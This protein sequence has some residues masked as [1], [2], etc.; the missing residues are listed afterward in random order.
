MWI[1]LWTDRSNVYLD[2]GVMIKVG[3]V[4]ISRPAVTINPDGVTITASGAILLIGRRFR[5][6]I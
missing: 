1:I 6:A 4:T 5:M 2:I 3:G